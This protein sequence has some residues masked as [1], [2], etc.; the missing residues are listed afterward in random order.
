VYFVFGQAWFAPPHRLPA[1]SAPHHTQAELPDWLQQS[2]SAVFA[3]ALLAL[4]V[5]GFLGWRWS[6]GRRMPARLATLAALWIPLPYLL[7]HGDYFSG[8]RLPLDGIL[9]CF[10]AFA[11]ARLLPGGSELMA[12]PTEPPAAGEIR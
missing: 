8:P 3:G 4:L 1:Q 2:Q 12:T 5:L 7:T 11:L 10:S 6:L 9:I